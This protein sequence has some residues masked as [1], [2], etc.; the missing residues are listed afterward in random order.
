MSSLTSLPGDLLLEIAG[1]LELRS[2]LLHFSVSVSSVD[3]FGMQF[4]QIS[5]SSTLYSNVVSALYSS[6]VLDTFRQC[7]N[8]LTMLHRHP[9]ITRH[10]QTLLVRPNGGRQTTTGVGGY[11]VC[12]AIRQIARQLDALGTFVWDWEEGFPPCDELWFALRMS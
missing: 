1:F 11:R 8:T 3:D 4:T 6:V 5:Q 9:E 7:I 2:D 10:I 12:S